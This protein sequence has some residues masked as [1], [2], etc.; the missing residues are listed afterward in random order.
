MVKQ[1]ISSCT[2]TEY[3]YTVLFFDG[4]KIMSDDF[5][6]YEKCFQLADIRFC[7]LNVLRIKSNEFH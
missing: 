3:E 4:K 1:F 7:K 5:K 6:K 2:T